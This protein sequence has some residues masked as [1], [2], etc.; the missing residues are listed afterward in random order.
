MRSI[1]ANFLSMTFFLMA[2]R[3]SNR[4][5]GNTFASMRPNYNQG[6]Y[7]GSDRDRY[8]NRG[9]NYDNRPEYYDRYPDKPNGGYRGGNGY[10]GGGGGSGGGFGSAYDDRG[11]RPWDQT[12]T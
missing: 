5:Y 11:F 9:D 6:N 4:G 2:D 10:F 12:Y 3:M 1:F 7:G 8:F